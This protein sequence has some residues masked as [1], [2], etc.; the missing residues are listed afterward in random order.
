MKKIND[1]FYVQYGNSLDLAS[2]TQCNKTNKN[3]INFVSRTSKN[4][5][6]SAVVEKIAGTKPLPEGTLTVAVG[7]SVMETFLQPEKYYTGYHVL[8]L[9]PKIEMTDNEKLYYCACIRTNKY[10]YNYG[11][12]ANKTL[13]DI[14]VPEILQ[15]PDFVEQNSMPD[16]SDFSGSLNNEEIQLNTR[17]WKPFRYDELF[18]IERG[19]GPRKQDLDD[20]NIPFI[21]STDTNN[22]LTAYTNYV[23]C[24]NGNTI[25]VNRNGSVGEAFYQE[26]P[27]CST[28]DVHVFNPKFKMNKYIAIFFISL[29]RKEK[30]RFNYGRKWGIDRMNSSIIKLPIKK[31][32][33]PNFEFMDRYIKSLQYSSNI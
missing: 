18:N 31:D 23:P 29:I 25:T 17:D 33:T 5:G 15:I 27:F 3:A 9:T 1:L 16:Y 11:R 2:L 32:G 24:H 12:Q 21:T 8:V 28:E 26:I 7:G 4:N 19:K 10:K 20:G 6:V 14:I 13:K 22:G 30:Y